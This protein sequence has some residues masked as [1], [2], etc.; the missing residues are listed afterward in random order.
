M[1][2]PKCPRPSTLSDGVTRKRCRD[3]AS[4][5]EHSAV[6]VA[7]DCSA[8][9]RR[10]GLVA[11]AVAVMSSA[12]ASGMVAEFQAAMEYLDSRMC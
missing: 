7:V 1:T 3:T 10:G 11:D 9:G 12:V 5:V 2:L 8:A 4:P 6:A